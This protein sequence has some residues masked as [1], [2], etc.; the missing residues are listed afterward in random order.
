MLSNL[1]DALRCPPVV[2]HCLSLLFSV[3]STRFLLS[4]LLSSFV[5][6]EVSELSGE[7]VDLREARRSVMCTSKVSLLE[8]THR[9]GNSDYLF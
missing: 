2:A 8:S 1:Q 4:L 6:G 3:S 7:I 9:D 5:R